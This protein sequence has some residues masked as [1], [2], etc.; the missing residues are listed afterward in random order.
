MNR[1]RLLDLG[2]IVVAAAIALG[3]AGVSHSAEVTSPYAT[4]SSV[5]DDRAASAARPLALFIGD[6]YTAGESTAELSYA[7][8]AA[9]RMG[10][11]C[12]LSAVGG[13]GYI[14]GGPANRWD[15]PYTGKSLSYIERI[16]AL[17]A[18]YDPDLVVL[19]GGR[20]DDFAPRAY[21]F[22]ETVSTISEVRRAWPRAQIVF[23]RP[24]FLADP[25]DDLGMTDQFIARL[26]ATPE[27]KG[28]VFID[29]LSALSG[30]D[31]SDLIAS[32][33]IHP[34]ARGEQHILNALIEAL[35]TQ[36]VRAP[37]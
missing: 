34:N 10:W 25:R 16:P 20:N 7:C 24:R 19:D 6:S 31:T 5:R 14:S 4:S 36:H 18:K 21:A 2:A 28:V 22:E 27:A 12:A 3:I 15:D 9:L 26:Q 1:T 23:I 11:L 29:P 33:N 13:T 32:D 35:Q 37:S 8:R 17:S 30:T